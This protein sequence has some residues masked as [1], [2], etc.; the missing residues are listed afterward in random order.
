MDLVTLKD[1]IY[2]VTPVGTP[3]YAPDDGVRRH[4]NPFYETPSP[5]QPGVYDPDLLVENYDSL[6][7]KEGFRSSGSFELKTVDI[8][9]T[10]AKLPKGMLVSLRDTNEVCIVTTH[11]I[12]TDDMDR[13]ILTVKGTSFLVWLLENRP[14]WAYQHNP[15][16]PTNTSAERINLVF[17]IPDHLAFIIWAATVFPHAEGGYPT[18]H[19]PFE[20]P[21]NIIVPHVAVSQ[22]IAIKGDYFRTEWP[23]P[24]ETRLTSVN[25]ILELDQK[26]GIRTIRPKN[27]SALVY[28]PTINGLR[29]EGATTVTHNITKMLFDVYQGRD[30]TVGEN[31]VIF[32]QDSGDI[33]TSEYISSIEGYRVMVSTHFD[34]DGTKFN[35]LQPPTVS[36]LAWQGDAQLDVSGNPVPNPNADA[37][38]YIAGKDFTM[39]DFASNVTIPPNDGGLTDATL[40]R[41]QSD[42]FKYL[43]EHKDLDLMTA[44]IS[45]HT[46][47]KYKQDYDLGDIV[48]VQGKYGT[49]EKMLVTEYTRTSDANGISGFPTLVRWDNPNDKI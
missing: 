44:E 26:Y 32:R 18:S 37:R 14:T 31:R 10:R 24:I 49:V 40:A 28:S 20:L 9:A 46:Q 25:G 48:F 30:L 3:P 38:K 21:M 12:G 29:G 11:H 22:T 39:G 17:Q 2:P 45:Q 4:T 16:N 33:T 43:R 23:P 35:N 13:D 7:W 15:A 19:K 6:I 34:V 5:Y 1:W 36:I 27:L 42:A 41:I 47:Y 8:E